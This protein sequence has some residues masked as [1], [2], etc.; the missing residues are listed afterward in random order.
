MSI[1]VLQPPSDSKFEDKEND[2]TQANNNLKLNRTSS[3][4]DTQKNIKSM[5]G[6]RKLYTL[7]ANNSSR[8]LES[9]SY[10]DL[11]YKQKTTE[12]IKNPKILQSTSNIYS[13]SISGKKR[14][15]KNKVSSSE[16][17]KLRSHTEAMFTGITHKIKNDEIG[18]KENQKPNSSNYTANYD[19]RLLR[20]PPN[21]NAVTK[22][23]KATNLLKKPNSHDDQ[24]ERK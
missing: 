22:Q 14:H 11:N 10:R 9:Q 6:I 2:F 23:V 7:K 16:T 12:T 13:T 8:R 5:S 21:P 17:P 3:G 4:R 20:K 18:D 24:E 19:T 15:V 1:G